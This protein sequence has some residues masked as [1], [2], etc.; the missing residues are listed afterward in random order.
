MIYY[1]EGQPAE[2]NDIVEAAD[3][4]AEVLEE[5][6]TEVLIRMTSKEK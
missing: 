2:A 1:Y 3:Q 4:V 6:R 5:E